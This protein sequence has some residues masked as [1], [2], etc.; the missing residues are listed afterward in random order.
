MSQS[1]QKVRSRETPP[2]RRYD[3]WCWL[4]CLR[5]CLLACLLTCVRRPA[6]PFLPPTLLAAGNA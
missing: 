1:K 3:Y 4:A 5:V 6:S 2:S